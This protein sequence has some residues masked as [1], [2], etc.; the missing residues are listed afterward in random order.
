MA[1]NFP[2]SMKGNKVQIQISQ[3][4]PSSV[5]KTQ[6]HI[7]SRCIITTPLKNKGKAKILKTT[8]GGKDACVPREKIRIRAE[9][10][11]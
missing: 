9:L 6:N 3:L 1:K 4:K 8:R 5:N 2:L 7:Y 10:S 11:S